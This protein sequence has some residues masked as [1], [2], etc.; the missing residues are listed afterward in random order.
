VRLFIGAPVPPSDVFGRVTQDLVDTARGVR[1]V[2]AGTW[3]VTLRFLGVLPEAGPPAS[4][5][6]E[7]LAGRSAVPVRVR[8]VGAFQ[9]PRRAR[10][11][12][13]G[14]DAPGLDR[15]EGAVRAATAHLGEPPPRRDFVPH[16]TLARLGRPTDVSAWVHHHEATRFSEGLLDTVVLYRSDL[17]PGGPTYTRVHE[18]RLGDPAAPPPEP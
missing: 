5:L 11:A 6:D 3:H 1:P 10:I 9:D 16:V 14:V 7:A 18:V 17:G 2:P 13:A 12:W 15:V 4:A 8:G